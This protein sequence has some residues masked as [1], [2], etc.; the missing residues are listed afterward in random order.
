M[1]L[2]AVRM[3]EDFDVY[4]DGLFTVPLEIPGTPYAKAVKA[5]KNIVAE[6]ERAHL[7]LSTSVLAAT[8]IG[9]NTVGG[10]GLA[11]QS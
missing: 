10:V 3:R 9:L 5:R 2:A 4:A 7:P 1:L 6:I 8:A 11:R